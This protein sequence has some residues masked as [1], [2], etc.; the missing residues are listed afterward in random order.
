MTDPPARP[1]IRLFVDA[2]LA[3][4]A[5]VALDPAQAHY[6]RRV[7]R[8]GAG[9]PVA[10]FNGRDGEWRAELAGA[11]LLEAR[12]QLR[13]QPP[14]RGP[15]LA[16]APPRRP[17]LE[18][19]VEK[20]AE[21]GARA[22]QPVALRRARPIGARPERLRARA[23]AAAEQCGRLDVPKVAAPV[24]LPELLARPAPL[25][26]GD[27]RGRPPGEVLPG[28]RGAGAVLLVGPEGGFDGG[29]RR[30]LAAS[31]AARPVALGP[32]VLRVETAALALLALWRAFAGGGLSGV[33]ADAIQTGGGRSET[34]GG[35]P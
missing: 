17:R 26:W 15:V 20:A 31:G 25:A 30:M 4:G 6:L 3:A 24:P 22:L 8:L 29:E 23:V 2:P 7:M 21:L 28:M 9:A 13:P 10:V 14:P 1:R 32:L 16:F 5:P 11:A 18:L 19:L 12:A 27:P 35:A 33:G 34:M